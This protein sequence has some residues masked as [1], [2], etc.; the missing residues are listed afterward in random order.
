MFA[1]GRF[2]ADLIDGEV[3]YPSWEHGVAFPRAPTVEHPDFSCTELTWLGRCGTFS[4]DAHLCE[5]LDGD[6]R[7]LPETGR[8]LEQFPPE[9]RIRL[10]QTVPRISCGER[11][12]TVVLDRDYPII[13]VRTWHRDYSHG[14]PRQFRVELLRPDG[15]WQAHSVVNS[16]QAR[17]HKWWE[18]RGD[19]SATSAPV[20]LTFPP[21]VAHRVRFV[22]DTCST[23]SDAELSE[24]LRGAPGMEPGNGWLYEIEVFARLSPWQAWRRQL[25]GD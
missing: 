11:A 20:T 15:T 9:R 14:A 1:C 23:F 16:Y 18:W 5:R 22:M 3:E 2:P 25:L 7:V 10:G 13:A 24:Y 21:T 17:T 12:I 4:P 8:D 19:G 6:F